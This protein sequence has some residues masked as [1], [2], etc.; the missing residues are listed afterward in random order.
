M[1]D[2]TI[3]KA[4]KRTVVGKKVKNLRKEGIVPAN[5]FGNKFASAAIQVALTDFMKVFKASGETQ[6]IYV[7]YDKEEVPTL[8]RSVQ[9]HNL[10]NKPLHI[11]FQ[12]V[13][14]TKKS[15]A[16]VPVKFVG[17]S[18]AVHQNLGDLLNLAETLNVEA[19]PTSVPHD[20]EVD[21]SSLKQVD[22][23]ITVADLKAGKDY[24]F[25]DDPT[26]PVAKIA[27]KQEEVV[28]EAPAEVVPAEGTAEGET[29]AEGGEAAAEEK[30]TEE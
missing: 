6:V 17:E 3:L 23:M 11:D 18:E 13:D 28:A 4:E 25:L 26:T 9:L 10:T 24:I 19:L 7:T 22:D 29:P 12:K 8:V 14:L 1:S 21:I 30:P 20:I 16:A 5:I 27:A 15:H 2:K